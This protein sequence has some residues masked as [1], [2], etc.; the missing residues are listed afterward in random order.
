MT[1]IQFTLYKNLYDL[2]NNGPSFYHQ[3]D[4]ETLPEVDGFFNYN[5][6]IFELMDE[7]AKDTFENFYGLELGRYYIYSS[8][9]YTEK[10]SPISYIYFAVFD[11][12]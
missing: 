12:N 10:N 4:V 3:F 7:E 9:D 5:K 6:S 1:K 2:K 8:K 11:G